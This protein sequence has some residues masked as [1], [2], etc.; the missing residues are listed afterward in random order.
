MSP[1]PLR[2]V[3]AVALCCAA[4]P[5][6]AAPDS[7]DRYR[8]TTKMQMAGMSMPGKPV[9]VC[10]ARANPVSEQAIPKDKDCEVQGFRIEGS[11]A[12]YHVVCKGKNAMT[13][14][15]EM[16]TLPDGYRGSMK[17]QVEGQQITMSYEGKRIGSCDYASESPEAIGKAMTAQACEAQLTSIPSYSMYVGPKAAC[18]AWKDKFCANVSRSMAQAGDPAHFAETDRSFGGIA[19][20]AVEACGGGSRATFLAKAC[21]RAEGTSDLD[22]VGDMC[23]D[24][25]PKHCADADPNRNGRFLAQHCAERARTL[26]AQQCEGR[27]YT[28][29]QSSPYRAFCGSYATERLRAR[30]E[31]GAKGSGGSR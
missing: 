23:P 1:F 21:A 8:V 22:F 31:A 16:E 14:D 2:T 4:I 17:A 13:G 29:M 19:W 3:A 20:Q 24:L 6:V 9:E 30:G 12:S 7:G 11:K 5:A 18:P 28:A 27:G 26:A 25:A 15:G 10:T